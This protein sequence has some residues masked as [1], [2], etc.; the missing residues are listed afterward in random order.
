MKSNALRFAFSF[1]ALF[2]VACGVNE[3]ATTPDTTTAAASATTTTPNGGAGG[4]AT[5]SVGGHHQGGSVPTTTTQPAAGGSGPTTTSSDPGPGTQPST[6]TT[7]LTITFVGNPAG[8]YVDLRTCMGSPVAKGDLRDD[9]EAQFLPWPSQHNAPEPVADLPTWLDLGN[10]V[11]NGNGVYTVT[12]PPVWV[13]ASFRFQ[14]YDWKGGKVTVGCVNPDNDSV[15][16]KG[17]NGDSMP[18]TLV[19][20]LTEKGMNCQVGWVQMM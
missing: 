6:A 8:Q 1:S 9:T 15:S 18:Y 17:A 4:G 2:T 12:T 20:N 7:T 14:C 19:D 5:T 10:A 16:V 13:D 3:A 11:V